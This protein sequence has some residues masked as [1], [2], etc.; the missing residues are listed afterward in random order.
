[1]KRKYMIPNIQVVAVE[2][3]LLTSASPD[4][5]MTV[6]KSTTVSNP[7]AV[8]GRSGGNWDDDE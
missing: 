3:H 8:L 7:D 5:K 2:Q 1:M 6:N 4:D